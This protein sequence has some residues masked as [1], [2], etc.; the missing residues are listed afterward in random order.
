[1]ST[2]PIR[3]YEQLLQ[4]IQEW[5]AARLPGRRVTRV[6][7]DLADGDRIQ[8]PV[9]ATDGAGGMGQGGAAQPAAGEPF[10]PT[11]FQQGILEALEGKAL[12]TDALGAAVGDRSRLF[13]RHARTGQTPLQ[14][15]QALGLVSHHSRLGYFRPDAPPP[16][17]AQ[18]GE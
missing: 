5:V 1:M 18:E 9:D 10:V 11:P 14:E 17:L 15:L 13:R 4:L 7:I 3:T 2:R 16:Q 12:R 8:L 6:R